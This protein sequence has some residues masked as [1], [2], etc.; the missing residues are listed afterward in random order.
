MGDAIWAT[1]IMFE[2]TLVGVIGPDRYLG[3]W[4]NS[5]QFTDPDVRQAIATYGRLLEY[6]NKDHAA[7]SWPGFT[8][9]TLRSK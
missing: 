7:L 1:G 8:I 5:T 9:W 2:N 4:D 3:L 6:L